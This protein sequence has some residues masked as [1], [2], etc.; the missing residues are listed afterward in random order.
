[1]AKPIAF[2]SPQDAG[3]PSPDAQAQKHGGAGNRDPRRHNSLT[4]GKAVSSPLFLNRQKGHL[5]VQSFQ[6]G[7]GARPGQS[8]QPAG[9]AITCVENILLSFALYLIV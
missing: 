7:Q 6:R 4:F 3:W 8:A 5:A 1:M 9:S 2:V